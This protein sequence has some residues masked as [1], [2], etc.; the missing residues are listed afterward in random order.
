MITGD[1]PLTACHV[2][3]ELHFLQREHTLILQPPVSKG[4]RSLAGN[5]SVFWRTV[6]KALLGHCIKVSHVLLA[7]LL[8]A[9]NGNDSLS[10]SL[11]NPLSFAPLFSGLEYYASYISSSASS[12]TKPSEHQ[13]NKNNSSLKASLLCRFRGHPGKLR[14]MSLEGRGV[15]MKTIARWEVGMSLS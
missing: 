9:D 3:R 13:N 10:R 7:L 2:A 4:N 14:A 15:H 8:D 1:N 5:C 11:D 6:A 12:K